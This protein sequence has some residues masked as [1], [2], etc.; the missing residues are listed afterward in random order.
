MS[1]YVSFKFDILSSGHI[2]SMEEKQQRFEKF[3]HLP[4]GPVR[5]HVVV[6]SKI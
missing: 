6:M 3:G 2:Y 4:Q 1:P 5:E